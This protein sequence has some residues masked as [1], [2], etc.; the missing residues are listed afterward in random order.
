[1]E[2]TE[3][4]MRYCLEFVIDHSNINEHDTITRM[5]FRMERENQITL[6]EVKTLIL[7]LQYRIISLTR[8]DN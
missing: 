5:L 7:K 6:E 2:T 3:I 4:T 8:I 1:M